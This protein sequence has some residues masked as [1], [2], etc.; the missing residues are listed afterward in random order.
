MKKY[1]IYLSIIITTI[2]ATY[3]VTTKTLRIETIRSTDEGA[4]LR[5]NDEEYYINL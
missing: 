2:L 4:I 1:I 3:T 5:V